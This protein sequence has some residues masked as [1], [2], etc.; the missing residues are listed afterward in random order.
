MFN[1]KRL[2]FGLLRSQ[3]TGSRSRRARRGFGGSRMGGIGG[4]LLGSLA[5]TAL[6]SY[7]ERQKS[8]S[9]PAPTTLPPESTSSEEDE[10]AQVLV[11]VMISAAKADGE[12][13]PAER[14]RILD[15]S[16]Q[17]GADEE[18]R[19]FLQRELEKPLDLD[20]LLNRIRELQM[21]EEAYAASLLAIEVDTPAEQQYL[22]Y[23]ATRLNL[24]AETVAQLHERFDAPRPLST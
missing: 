20:A 23:L 14:Q 24:E 21:A 4:A 15:E 10:A 8:P 17:A 16:A 2:L 3:I 19:A 22:A 9:S 1:A 7:M 11:Q 12:V 5:T 18:E 6:Q 13:S